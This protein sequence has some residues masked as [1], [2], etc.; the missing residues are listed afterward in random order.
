MRKAHGGLRC[1]SFSSIN[2]IVVACFHLSP[3]ATRHHLPQIGCFH[4]RI[5]RIGACNRHHERTRIIYISDDASR[6]LT[7]ARRGVQLTDSTD[8]RSTPTPAVPPSTRAQARVAPHTV[9]QRSDDE[10]HQSRLLT[11]AIL[12]TPLSSNRFPPTPQHQST[13]LC[14]HRVV[15]EL[16]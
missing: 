7:K 12:C 2:F 10:Q 4:R 8:R 6:V 1:T 14:Q 13:H 9:F 16:S 11:E 5:P 15:L 3:P